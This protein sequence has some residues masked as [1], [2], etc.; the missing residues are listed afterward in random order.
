MLDVVDTSP[1]LAR[2]TTLIVSWKSGSTDTT[3]AVTALGDED[4]EAI[5]H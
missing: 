1:G 2:G 4:G 5:Y 3:H